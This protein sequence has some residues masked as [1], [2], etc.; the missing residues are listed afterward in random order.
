M[1][2]SHRLLLLSALVAASISCGDVVRDSRSPMFLVIDSLQGARS[3]TTTFSTIVFSDVL[4]IVTS[5]GT[6][7]TTSPCPTIFGDNGQV[8][9]RLSQKDVTGLAPTSNNDVTITSYHVAYRRADGRNTQGVDVPFAFDGAVTATVPSSGTATI[10]FELVRL[11][12][13]EEPP[14][15]QLVTS[16][17]SSRRWP[18]SRSSGKTASGTTCR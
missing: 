3:P 4:T 11:T 12:A 2:T 10:G 18:T 13:K 7:S 17:R 16:G 5:G 1:R 14:L 15:V 9:L 6:C 8:T